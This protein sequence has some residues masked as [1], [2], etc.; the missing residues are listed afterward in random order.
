M[1]RRFYSSHVGDESIIKLHPIHVSCTGYL[2]AKTYEAKKIITHGCL[3]GNNP[4]FFT[5]RDIFFSFISL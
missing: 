4:K 5:T 2:P 1:K 3:K